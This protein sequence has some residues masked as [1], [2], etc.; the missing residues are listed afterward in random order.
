[1]R[2]RSAI[3]CRCRSRLVGAVFA[4]ALGTA[5]KRG[6][7]ISDVEKQRHRGPKRVGSL[8]SSKGVNI[9]ASRFDRGGSDELASSSAVDNA[10]QKRIQHRGVGKRRRESRSADGSGADGGLG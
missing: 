7:T 8:N 1:M 4:V 5:L 2:P 6:G 9:L 10:N 3:S